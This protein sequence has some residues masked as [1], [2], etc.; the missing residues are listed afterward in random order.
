VKVSIKEA[1][2]VLVSLL[3]ES[4]AEGCRWLKREIRL[5]AGLPDVEIINTLDKIAVTAKE[6]VHFGFNFN[7]PNPRN[8]MDIPLGVAEVDADFFLEANRNWICFQRWL[9]ISNH[10]RGVVWC[11]P[12]APL[13]QHGHITANIMGGGGLGSPPWIRRL[14]PSAT[15]YSWALNNHWFTNFPL[16][17]EGVLTFRYGILPRDT[18]YD[19]AVANRFGMEQARPLIAVRT[20]TPVHITPP[21]SIDNCRVLV[22]SLKSEPEG[23]VVTLR[24]LSDRPETVTIT[25]SGTVEESTIDMLPQGVDSETFKKIG[26]P[27][28]SASGRERPLPA[29]PSGS[30]MRRRYMVGTAVMCVRIVLARWRCILCSRTFTEHRDLGSNWLRC[31]SYYWPRH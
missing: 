2:P 23:L 31:C 1:G 6:G 14:E 10:E 22:S 3:V 26:F 9:D 8:R 19:A 24:S 12:D 18:P 20:A 21:V 28:G 13:F 29:R 4:R 5:T 25:R 16:S 15:V 11:A 27:G 7:I 17:Q 30:V